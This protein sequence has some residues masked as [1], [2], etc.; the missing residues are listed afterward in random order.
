MRVWV[1]GATGVVGREL[2]S[3]LLAT[4]AQVR[5]ITR[6]RA[7]ARLPGAAEIVVGDPSEPLEI[8]ESCNR[9]GKA[10]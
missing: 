7:S 8:A 9:N 5:A 6:N 3:Q 10:H 4:G 2:V 1:A